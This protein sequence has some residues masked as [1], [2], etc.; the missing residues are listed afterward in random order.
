VVGDRGGAIE[1]EPLLGPYA[2]RE[3]RELLLE[4]AHGKLLFGGLR[5]IRGAKA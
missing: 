1:D 3:T 4:A 2:L 5:L